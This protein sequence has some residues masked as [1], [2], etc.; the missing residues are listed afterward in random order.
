MNLCNRLPI[1]I[2]LFCILSCPRIQAQNET[3]TMTQIGAN[4][5][6]SVPF[7]LNYGPDNYLWVTEK[8]AGKVVRINPTT[9]Q[10][11][12]LIQIAG[13]YSSGGQ[14]GLLGFAFDEGFLTGSPYVYLSHT[15]GTSIANEKQRLVR[16]TYSLNGN[17]GSLSS[18]VILI[19]NLPAYND[20]NSGRLLFG[21]DK[22]LY[23]TIGDQANKA[24]NT[25]LA[26]FLPTQQEIDAKNWAKYPGKLLRLNT[27]GTIPADNP[28]INGVK[29][30]IYTYGHRNPQGLVFGTNGLLY[31]DEQGPSSDDEINIMNSGKNYGWPFVAGIKD[32]LQY[33]TDGCLAGNETSFTATN[34]QDPILSMFLPNSYKDPA[35][36]DSWMCRPN[37]APSSIAIYES[38]AIPSWK[39]SLLVTSLKKGRIYRVKLNA[40]GTAVEQNDVTQLF[41]TQNRYRDIVVSPD[42]KSFYIITDSSGKTSDASGMNTVSTMSNPGA[43]LKFTLKENLST[44]Q[45]T[46]TFFRIWPNPV[47]HTLF[48]E[49]KD[50]VEKAQLI[51]SLGQVTREFTDLKTGVNELKINNIPKGVYILKLY[52]KGQSWQ[53]TIIVN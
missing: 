19:D 17:D 6:L 15:V 41:Y 30:H 44:Q 23:Y 28:T 49:L 26:Q 22:K 27:D 20:H 43:I 12:E 31:S 46:A 51:N 3:F 4:N 42:G 52:S 37:I 11:D 21:P 36:T 47:S 53:K 16:Y 8:T 13:A 2:L 5:L 25:N 10:R 40:N 29:S 38:D 14:D 24:C 35:C 7:D 1:I 34:Y 33:D 45:E 48:I 50:F 9:G 39:N 32:N 18:P